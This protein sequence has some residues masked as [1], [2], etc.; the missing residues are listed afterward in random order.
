MIMETHKLNMRRLTPEDSEQYTDLERYAFQEEFVDW[1]LENESEIRKAKSLILKH[2]NVLGW[3]DEGKLVSQI[4]VYP[5]QMNIFGSV[6]D[7]GFI[8]NVATYPEYSGK[9]LMSSLMK[10]CLTVMRESGQSISILY[11]Y[12]IPLYRHKGWEIISDKMTF[13]IKDY[14]LPKKLSAPG[15][16]RRVERDSEDLIKLHEQFAKQTH[17]CIF[18]NEMAWELY[19]DEDADETN[20]AI[21][22]DEGEKPCGY[23]VYTIEED[24]FKIREMIYLNSEARKGLWAYVCAH[25]S[26]VSDVVGDNYSGTPIA[27]LLEDSDI[28]ETIR[29]YMMGR[30]VDFEQFLKKYQFRNPNIDRSITFNV[31]DSILEWNNKSFTVKFSHSDDPKIVDEASEYTVDLSIGTL[32]TML[33]GYKRPSYLLDMEYLQNASNETINILEDIIF[34][35]KP[36]ISDY[37]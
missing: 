11:P 6:Y 20:I 36:Y 29:P 35:K 2:S 16:I 22:Y 12:S 24:V 26:M 13:N 31:K 4:A 28:K 5:M 23:V 3:F 17:G 7:T 25:V 10:Q 19:W 32:T 34:D 37:I 9:G 14:Q 21:Y 33:L 18:R 1:G 30:I 27:F 15:N 8:T